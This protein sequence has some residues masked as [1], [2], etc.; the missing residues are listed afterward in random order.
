MNST[1]KRFA[2][3]VAVLAMA[4]GFIGVGTAASAVL[5]THSG[6]A[7][8][9]YQARTESTAWSAAPAAGVWVNVPNA[10]ITT[11]VPAG[12]VRTHEVTFSAESFCGGTGGWCSVRVLRFNP[13]GTVTELNPISGTDFAFDS[14]GGDTYQSGAIERTGYYVGAGTYRFQVQAAVVAGATSVRLDD[15]GMALK[16]YRS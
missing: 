12:T 6:S 14:A 15:W 16:T 3:V 2:R 7:L 9:M 11:V 4:I 8:T 1:K 10:V 5:T 13:N